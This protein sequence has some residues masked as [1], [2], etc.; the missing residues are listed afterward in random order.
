M[1]CAVRVETSTLGDYVRN[2]V[3]IHFNLGYHGVF[4]GYNIFK[5][6]DNIG[7]EESSP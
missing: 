2:A 7:C 5:A 6:H 3:L 4:V 1:H